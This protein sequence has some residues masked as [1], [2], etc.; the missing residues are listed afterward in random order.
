[1]STSDSDDIE[2]AP[3]GADI[4]PGPASH[5][6][7]ASSEPGAAPEGALPPPIAP[8]AAAAGSDESAAS[9]STSEAVPSPHGGMGAVLHAQ[10]TTFRVWAPNAA[11]VS[12][13][14]SINE[15]SADANPL[16]H[17]GGG[18]WSADLPGVKAGDEYKFVIHRHEGGPL[19]RIDPYARDVTTSVGNS[20]VV[21]PSFDWGDDGGY[22]TPAWNEAVIY[23]L[24]AGTF[25]DH[26][27]GGPG[28]FEDVV[29]R[30]DYLRDLGIN[31]IELMP[32][33]E[34]AEDF[35]WGYNPAHIFAVESAFGGPAALKRLVR[36]AHARG[37][38]V[39]MDVVYNHLGPSD[40]DL[41]RF[42]G[43]YGESWRDARG[44]KHDAGGIYFY[45][46]WRAWTEWGDTRPDYGRP[47]VRQFL[48][49][50]ARM[51]LHEFR[52]DGLRW[53]A[54]AYIRNV[55]GHQG[56]GT[57]IPEGWGLM[58]RITAE[59]RAD[60]P[61]KLHVAEDMRNDEWLVKPVDEGGAGF[62]SQ[63]DGE[64]I[65]PLRALLWQPD[66]AARDMRA[67]RHAIEH[68]YAGDAFRRV[69]YT[70]SHD[71]VAR[72][73]GK[74][75]V[76]QQIH[77][78]DPGGWVAKKRSTLGAA[79]VFTAP[80]IPMIFQGQELL[81]DGDWEDIDPVDWSKETRFAGIL[82]MYRD[83]IHLR[84]DAWGATRGLRGPH[85][86]VHHVNHA[87]KVVAFHRRDAGGP[88]DDVIVVANFG[89]RAYGHYVIGFPRG[90]EWKVR[91]NS[92][93]NGYSPDFGN[94]DSWHVQ[95]EGVPRDEMPFSAGV[96]IGPYTAIILSQD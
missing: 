36:E 58:Q 43:W 34:F 45:N 87:D 54:T 77:P 89:N 46:D 59:S 18:Y 56:G 31:C 51:W 74:V 67:V 83:L 37:I 40:L 70:E 15:W 80:G 9:A 44:D 2:T 41:W 65:H 72:K 96:G 86:Q 53:D 8:G 1:M 11:G 35:S 20:V 6:P 32:P 39:L 5:A 55:Y 84:R 61:W 24:H 66:D 94:H 33:M 13:A 10:G 12:V 14:G 73:N 79:L 92:D 88:G 22:R 90:G 42:D 16:A 95:A 82:Q 3:D 64:F 48:R 49:D 27:G 7:A 29:R 62:G 69:V 75:R 52:L 47:E 60:H 76:P 93:W 63:W 23:E 17:D 91:F 71:E 50:N 19:W 81:E 4:Q 26:P 25:N 28:T 21:D 38:A 78:G 68:R 85:V 30:L 57:D